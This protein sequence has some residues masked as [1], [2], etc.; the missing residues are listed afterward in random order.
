MYVLHIIIIGKSTLVSSHLDSFRGQVY[1]DF[2]IDGLSLHDNL[3]QIVSSRRLGYV[4]ERS[5]ILWEWMTVEE[6]LVMFGL[7]SYYDF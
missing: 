4:S 6:H 2:V 1:G 7:I 3:A 5:S